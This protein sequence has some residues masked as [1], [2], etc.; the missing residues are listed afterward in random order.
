VITVETT[1]P[2]GKYDSPSAIAT[3]YDGWLTR[4]SAVSGVQA[5]GLVNAPPLSGLEADGAFLLDGQAWEEIKGNWTAQSAVYRV[6]SEGYF[7]AMGMALRRG[8][9]FDRRDVDGAEPAAIINETLVRKHFAGRDP[10]GQRLRFAGMDQVNPWLT[11][12]GVVGDVR[13]SDLAAEAKPEVFV[14]F[15]QL[16]AR[17]RFGVTTAVRVGPGMSAEQVVAALREQWRGLDADVPVSFS[18]MTTLVE[19]STASR[20]FTLTVVSVFG[21]MALALAAM[22]VF[23]ILSYAVTQRAREIGIRMALG[24]TAGSVVGLVFRSVTGPVAAGVAGGVLAGALLTR[25]LQA[26]LFGVTT[27]DPLTFSAAVIV[28]IGVSFLAAWQPVRRAA[29]IDPAVVMRDE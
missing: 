7:E 24:A 11:I 20:R 19:R 13:F 16:P 12:V 8:R 28:L 15:R 27:L 18:S 10:I 1:V 22:G 17:L 21:V 6:A 29:R 5:A 25:F 26:F 14:N 9:G 2:E 4:M 23:G 3:L